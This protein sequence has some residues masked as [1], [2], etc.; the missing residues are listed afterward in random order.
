MSTNTSTS[1]HQGGEK[2]TIKMMTNGSTRKKVFK[3]ARK[4]LSLETSILRR[5][6]FLIHFTVRREKKVTA[7]KT[8]R[9]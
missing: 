7:I 6:I 9:D 8:E 4:K 1:E 3:I 5:G 2:R